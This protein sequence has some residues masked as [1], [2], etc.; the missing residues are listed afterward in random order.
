MTVVKL[1]CLAALVAPQ[2]IRTTHI[3]TNTV[4]FLLDAANRFPADRFFFCWFRFYL[5]VRTQ[6]F[7]IVRYPGQQLQAFWLPRLPGLPFGLL[8]VL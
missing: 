5:D 2:S 8:V 7:L 3:A 4:Q 6:R 1:K